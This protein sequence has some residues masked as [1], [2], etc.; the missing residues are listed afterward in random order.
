MKN[1]IL[2]IFVF[3]L[4]IFVV[5]IITTQSKQNKTENK[6][7]TENFVNKIEMY[8]GQNNIEQLEKNAQELLGKEIKVDIGE[9][10]EETDKDGYPQKKLKVNV[11][12][13]QNYPI[14]M[15]IEI[16]AFS[17]DEDNEILI[18]TDTKSIYNLE[19]NQEKEMDFFDNI[20]LSEQRKLANAKFRVINLEKI[21]PNLN[22]DF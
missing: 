13:L 22:I 17:N 9:F 18:R 16:A 11:V 14:T 6:F 5:A 20:T 3:F 15:N 1:K 7:L 10:V 4:I 21:L 2:I 12:N 8:E 19:A